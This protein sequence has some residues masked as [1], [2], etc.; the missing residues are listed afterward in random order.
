MKYPL[1]FSLLFASTI[2]LTSVS[3][4]QESANTTPTPPADGNLFTEWQEF[5]S[6]TGGFK[7]LFPK[8]PKQ[9]TTKIEIGQFQSTAYIFESQ[10]DLSCE[11]MYFD[12]PQAPD[13]ETTEP[14]LQGMSKFTAA[15]LKGRLLSG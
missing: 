6:K 14:L 3:F 5:S 13:A 11:V 8:P 2:I 12:T 4:A 10:D 9:K 7:A 1:S 15:E